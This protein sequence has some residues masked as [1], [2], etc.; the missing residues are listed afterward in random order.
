M[1]KRKPSLSYRLLSVAYFFIY[2]FCSGL[3]LG[4]YLAE[5]VNVTVIIAI[6]V[7]VVVSALLWVVAEDD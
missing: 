6:M 2:F 3:A 4:L 7:I 1:S 5:G